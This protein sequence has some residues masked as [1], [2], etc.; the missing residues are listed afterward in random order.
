MSKLYFNLLLI[1]CIYYIY[2]Q[3]TKLEGVP[4]SSD[5]SSQTLLKVFDGDLS[6]SFTS[7]SKEGWIGLE[8]SSP[9]KI[10]K[11]GFAHLSSEPKDYLLGVFQGANDKTFFDAFPLYMITEELEPNKINFFEISCSQSFKYIRYVGPEGKNYTLLEFEIYGNSN[12]NEQDENYYKPTNIPL[13]IINSEN[14]ELRAE[15]KSF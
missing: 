15:I 4:F 14:S 1:L 12:N 11:I 7:T 5:E 2:S 13:L 9:S 3:E 10:T 6:T 8:L